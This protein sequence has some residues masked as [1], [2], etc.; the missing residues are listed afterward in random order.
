MTRSRVINLANLQTFTAINALADL[1]SIGGPVK[2]PDACKVMPVWTNGAGKSVRN[3]LYANCGPSTAITATLAEQ[4]RAALVA[5]SEFTALLAHIAPT[6]AFAAIELQDVR[7]VHLPVVRSSGT[8]VAGT[9][10]GIELPDEVALVTTF[11]TNSI[12]PGHRGRMYQPGWASSALGAGNT[13]TAAAV[14]A[15]GNWSNAIAQVVGVQ[16]GALS[17]GLQERQAYT[18]ST[19]T[20]HPHR[21]AHLE[22][23]SSIIVRDNHWDSQRRRGLK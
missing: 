5:R 23:I 11:R 10:T 19:G 14:T 4:V 22:A 17:L 1:G 13:A 21:D 15:L 12:G 3:V 18:G 2:I 20:S 8:A 6:V 7:D 9:S 16:I